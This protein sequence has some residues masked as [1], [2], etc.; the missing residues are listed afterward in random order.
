VALGT[1][2]GAG[3]SVPP[4]DADP[5]RPVGATLVEEF[6]GRDL[7]EELIGYGVWPFAMDLRGRSSTAFVREVEAEA[8]KIVLWESMFR[9]RRPRGVGISTVQT[10]S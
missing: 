4:V 3:R 9:G 1:W 5:G 7:V 6:S 2:L 10:F 8:V